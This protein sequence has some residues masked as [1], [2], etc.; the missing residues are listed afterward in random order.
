MDVEEIKESAEE[1]LEAIPDNGKKNRDPAKTAF[2]MGIVFAVII[3]GTIIVRAWYSALRKENLSLR[4]SVAE[5]EE[6]LAELEETQAKLADSEQQVKLLKESTNALSEQV[7]G[8]NAEKEDLNN[9]LEDLLRVQE[10]APVITRELLDDEI[11][12]LSELVTKKYWYRNA[13]SK[14]EAKE[15]LWGADMPF[16]VPCLVRWL[17]YRRYR[18]EG[19]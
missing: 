9:Q 16:S 5:M 18:L 4:N 19:S 7:S 2:V 8:L 13:T 11:S 17:H 6:K 10:T 14:K 3:L 12:S 1:I 15:W